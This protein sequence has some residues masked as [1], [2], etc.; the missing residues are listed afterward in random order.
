MPTDI[1]ELTMV[2]KISSATS[3][4]AVVIPWFT[5]ED[6]AKRNIYIKL[7]KRI[8]FYKQTK[9]IPTM[10]LCNK[11]NREFYW[12]YNLSSQ[13]IH[14]KLRW[15]NIFLYVVKIRSELLPPLFF[16]QKSE[17]LTWEKKRQAIINNDQKDVLGK[18]LDEH[19]QTQLHNTLRKISIF[20]KSPLN[21]QFYHRKE[22]NNNYFYI[23]PFDK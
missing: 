11:V 16:H 1:S 9:S 13:T 7:M 12:Y 5:F 3:A 8:E 20:T 6:S 17:K 4:A 15:L 14:Q 10:Y 22:M 2:D 21:I 19:K 23:A 18:P